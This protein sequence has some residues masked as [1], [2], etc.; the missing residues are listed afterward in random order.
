[1]ILVID[2]FDSFTYNLVAYFEELGQEVDVLMN[3]C[4]PTELDLT[5][6]QGVVLSPGP[7]LPKDA[8]NLM[9][10]IEFIQ[11]K[12]PILGICLG[13]QALAEVNG[14]KLKRMKKP[15]HGKV[16]A[17]TVNGQGLFNQIPKSI[18]VVRYHSWLVQNLPDGFDVVAYTT[19]DEVMAFENDSIQVDGIQFHPESILTEYGREILNN[20]LVKRLI[21]S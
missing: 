21:V 19:E 9:I 17:I 12:L 2:N 8:N 5:K 11:G 4:E 13:H 1:V 10:L 6:Y 14:T 7:S 20:W 18:K 15:F 3:T 16:S